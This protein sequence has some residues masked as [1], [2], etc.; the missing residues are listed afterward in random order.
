MFIVHSRDIE[1]CS[2][3]KGKESKVIQG[4]DY[5]NKLFYPGEVYAQENKQ[6]AINKGRK[7]FL[8]GKS[9]CLLVESENSIR[10]WHHDKALKKFTNSD[11][12]VSIVNLPFLVRAMRDIGGVK[13]MDRQY[14]LRKYSRC[15]IGKEAVSWI[16]D[17]LKVSELEALSLGQRLMNEKYIHHVTD[18]H[19]FKNEYLFYRFHWDD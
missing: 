4:I 15:F 2:V 13:I 5:Q 17:Y 19:D 6:I 14:R 11:D 7:L 12:I 9:L 1:Y 8:E 18:D 10:L 16:M 3:I